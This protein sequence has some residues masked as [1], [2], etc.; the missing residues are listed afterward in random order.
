MRP[1]LIPL[2]ERLGRRALRRRGARTR[3]VETPAGRMHLYDVPG[4]GTLPTT[5]LL[6]GIGSNATPFGPL[7]ARLQR[8]VRRVIA[9]DYPGHGFSSPPQ[10]TLTPDA[11]F[12]AVTGVLDDAIDAPAILLGNSLGGALALHYAIARPEKVRALVLVSPAGAQSTDDEWR[13]LRAAFDLTSRASALRF[14]G[15]VYHR[16]PWFAQVVAHEVPASMHRRAVRELL[17]SATN[18]HS[19]AIEAIEALPMPVLFVWGQSERLLPQTHFDYFVKHLPKH[20]VIERPEG[21]GHC[22]HIDAPG[23]VAQRF[24]D[25]ARAI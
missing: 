12:E 25:F 13:A 14:L 5:V 10:G 24:V 16:T 23:A 7:L 19:P 11:L 8:H 2:V 9:P 4:H 3:W 18:E 17:A 22:P 6:H 21:F 20:A 1:I 15:R